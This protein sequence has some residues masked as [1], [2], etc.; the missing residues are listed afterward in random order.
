MEIGNHGVH[1]PRPLGQC[2]ESI[3]WSVDDPFHPVIRA[4]IER[5]IPSGHRFLVPQSDLDA[6]EGRFPALL[7]AFPGAIQATNEQSAAHVALLT[8]KNNQRLQP[9]HK[10][11]LDM[12]GPKS[13][14]QNRPSGT[15]VIVHGLLSGTTGSP[16][17]H[18][19]R[20]WQSI[21][22]SSEH[23]SKLGIDGGYWVTV[24]DTAS[25]MLRLGDVLPSHT[26]SINICGRR[27]WTAEDTWKELSMLSSRNAAGLYGTFTPKHLEEGHDVPVNVESLSVA[28]GQP[29]TRPDLGPLHTL[30]VSATGEGWNPSTPLRLGL[31]MML[32]ELTD[33]LQ[34]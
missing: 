32:A 33:D 15:A 24:A 8:G 28:V 3:V 14:T 21:V 12:A 23:P 34:S 29:P 19:F 2:M 31:M 18:V 9:G 30:L 6:V 1:Q 27:W 25:A 5:G 4:L 11:H 22:D 16:F 13:E 10:V 20:A 17:A 7:E 26:G